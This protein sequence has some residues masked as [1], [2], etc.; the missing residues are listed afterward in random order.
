MYRD[1]DFKIT[2]IYRSAGQAEAGRVRVRDRCVG[3]EPG[4]G[5]IS[6]D[7]GGAPLPPKPMLDPGVLENGDNNNNL[8]SPKRLCHGWHTI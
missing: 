8:C 2:Q 7:G 1:P 6:Y 5:G 4:G 3:V